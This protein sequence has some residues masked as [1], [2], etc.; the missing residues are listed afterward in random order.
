MHCLSEKVLSSYLDKKVTSEERQ[1][2]EAHI[3]ECRHCLGL[4]LLA[5]ESQRFSRKCPAAL[6]DKIKRKI[7]LREKKGRSELKWLF[8]A[9]FFFA[10]SFIFRRYFLQFLIAS[11][12]L[13]FKWSME[14]EAAKQVI[15]I[16]K[17]I[18]KKEKKFERKKPPSVSDITG[19]GRYGRDK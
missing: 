9:L 11:A 15:M 10:L 4:L 13:G 16:F 19:G 3:A 17:G 5:Y 8:G 6:K 7:G 18:E 14:G 2:I 12:V 1:K